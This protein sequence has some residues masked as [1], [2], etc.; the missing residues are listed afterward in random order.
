M[1][2]F[3]EL[4]QRRVI[5]AIAGYGVASFAILQVVEPIMHALRLPDATLTFSVVALGLGFPLV[6]VLA[7]AFDLSAAGVERTPSSLP[8]RGWLT[9]ARLLLLLVG[10]G[11]LAGAPGFALYFIAFRPGPV[12]EPPTPLPKITT[13]SVAVLPF[14]DLSPLKDQEY[15]SDGLAEEILNALAQIDL[16]HVTGRTSSFSFKGK[17]E[18]LR[19]IAEKLRVGAVLEGSV[20]KEGSRIRITAQLINASDGFHLWS[21]TFDRELIG[22]FAVQEEIA[23]AVVAALKV[24]LLPGE[25]PST[26]GHRTDDPEAY[27]HYL[28]ARQLMNRANAG[29]FRGSMVAYEESLAI[30]PGYAPA[31]AGL[32]FAAFYHSNL[33]AS[34]EEASKAARRALFAAEKAVAL[35]PNLAEGYA[36]RS[37]LRAA[38]SWDWPGAESDIKR[39]LSLSPG[40]A[41]GWRLFGLLQ[42]SLGR[43]PEAISAVRKAAGLDPLSAETWDNLGYLY[44]AQHELALARSASSRALVLAP[45]QAYAAHHLGVVELLEGKPQRAL[46][47]FERCGEEV[48]RLQGVAI[49][50]SDLKHAQASEKALDTLTARYAHNSAF[51]IAQVHAWRGDRDRA[52]EWLTRAFEQR[53]G[54]LSLLRCDPLLAK[55]RSD[56]RYLELLRKVSLP[57]E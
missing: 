20:R 29:G 17:N 11:L 5:R 38:I 3:E 43:L 48:F 33:S 16:L 50:Q 34:P 44:T 30:A 4:R 18:D 46:S 23:R 35:D 31:W 32:A 40:D 24:K 45:E 55:L 13:P 56:P 26:K 54:G 10:I 1:T 12:A 15:F 51:Q 7:W 25:T 47:L 22:V 49:A 19:T 57:I 27:S 9:R 39:A 14:V 2:F 41:Q 28:I 6:V 52:F 37:Y 8:R 36:A 21:Q 53:D 42:A